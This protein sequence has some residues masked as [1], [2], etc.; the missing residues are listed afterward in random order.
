MNLYQETKYILDKNNIRPNKKLGQNFLINE[1]AL[2][3][4]SSNVKSDDV[5]LEIGPGIGS[6]TKKLLDRANKVISIELDPKMCEILKQRFF[7]YE[8][9]ELINDDILNVDVNK[10]CKEYGNKLK[11]VANLPYYITTSILTHLLESDIQDITILIQKEV[12]DRITAIP[13]EKRAGAIT[14]LVYYYAN[15]SILENVS[16]ES[17]IPNPEVESSIVHISKLPTKR[18]QV[19]DETLFFR[20]IKENFTKRRKTIVNSISNSIPKEKLL[21][22]LNEL[23]ISENTRGEDLSIEKFAKI[24]NL[25]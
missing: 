15:S 4:I 11:V 16:K 5:V 17:F 12:A 14:Y 10:L 25:C 22:I 6:L 2:D 1:D 9:F 7:L 24:V 18:V 19:K 13:G 3:I 8:N 23:G 20:V 21:P